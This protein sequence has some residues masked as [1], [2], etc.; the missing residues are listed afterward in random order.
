VESDDQDGERVHFTMAG[1]QP[2]GDLHGERLPS[3]AAGALPVSRPGGHVL[4][5]E[6]TGERHQDGEG[7]GGSKDEL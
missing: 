2:F 1:A 7:D 6:K 3:A 5:P 4:K